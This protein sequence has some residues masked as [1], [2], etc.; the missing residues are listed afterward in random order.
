MSVRLNTP[1]SD[2]FLVAPSLL[3]DPVTFLTVDRRNGFILCGT[4]MG[5]V[6]AWPVHHLPRLMLGEGDVKVAEAEFKEGTAQP[7][8]QPSGEQEFWCLSL[9]KFS[10]EGIRY[11]YVHSDNRIF[12][13]VGDVHIKMWSSY[14][15]PATQ[16]IKF[17]RQHTY[18]GCATFYID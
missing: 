8:A 5:R 17:R 15:D 11:I 16:I 2:N 1:T 4:A 12:A 13:V 18:G 10:D 6:T 9:A 14:E 3:G 7:N